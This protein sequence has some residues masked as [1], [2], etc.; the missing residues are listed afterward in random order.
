[1]PGAEYRGNDPYGFMSLA[2]IVQYFDDYAKRFRLPVHCGVEVLSVEKIGYRYLVQQQR[3]AMIA[4]APRTVQ[5]MPDGLSR[6]PITVLQPASIT[7]DP[8]NKFLAR[9]S[10]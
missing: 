8:T 1:M 10:G 6:E 3:R 9:N 5:N 2:E 4:S 7:P